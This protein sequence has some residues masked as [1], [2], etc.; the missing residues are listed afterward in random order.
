MANQ[1]PIRFGILGAAKIVPTAL[2]EPAGKVP[3]AEVAAIAARDPKRAREFAKANRI[4]RVLASYEALV[5]DPEIDVIYNPLPNSLHCEWTI[6]A[7]RAGK[8]VLCEKPMASNA[9]EAEQMAQ[10]ADETGL[11]LVEAF[12]YRYHPLADRIRALIER[13][14]L[15]KLT[16]VE[17]HFSVPIPP[18]NIRF[19]WNLAGGATMDLG[20]YPLHMIRYF[21]G[22]T[23]RVTSAKAQVGPVNIDVAMEAE[24][25]LAPDVT[26]RMTCSMAAD[27]QLDAS[28][29][30][31]G[32]RGE[33]KV[34]NPVGPHWG[35]QLTITT[36]ERTTNET[37]PGD[38]TYT[39]QL[40]AFVAA[41]RGDRSAFPTDAR[42][43]VIGM[44][45]IDEVYRAAGL[46]SRGLK[47]D[48][49]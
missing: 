37:A 10:V 2:T 43:A 13:G 34:T 38:T 40:R 32:D 19:D 42:D 5:A 6:R 9:A 26:G 11:L 22:M 29:L 17:G 31:R 36:R 33:L 3:E 35:H 15:G 39:H 21:S 24:F 14:T 25:E 48:D 41:M 30:A 20:C 27:A 16:H 45:I 18:D 44:R 23:P 28:F 8:H 47:T 1:R 7:L 12:H 4:P 46:P 49:S